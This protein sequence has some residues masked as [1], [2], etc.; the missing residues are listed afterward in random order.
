MCGGS[1]Q[2]IDL[3]RARRFVASMMM[4]LVTYCRMAQSGERDLVV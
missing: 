1:G 2:F 3:Q 4:V